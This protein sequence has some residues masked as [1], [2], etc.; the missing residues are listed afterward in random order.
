MAEGVGLMRVWSDRL[1]ATSL[2]HAWARSDVGLRAGPV[3]AA[4]WRR[5]TQSMLAPGFVQ[6]GAKLPLIE[7]TWQWCSSRSKMAEASTSSPKTLPHSLKA[8]LLV[9][10]MEPHS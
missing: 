6:G 1:E 8:L 5:V 2:C 3:Y 4:W 7:M 10:R 9:A